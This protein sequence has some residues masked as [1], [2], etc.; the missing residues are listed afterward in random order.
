MSV[1]LSPARLRVIHG[2]GFRVVAVAFATALAFSTVPTPLYA[3]YQ[4][5]DGFP[6]F[7]VTVVFAA[8]AVGVMLSLYLA[9]HL[10]DWLGRR[11]VLVAGLLAEA[12]AAAMF[13]LW[14]DVPGLIIARL[15]SG[16]GI[17]VLSATATAHL[18]EL[19]AVVRPEAGLGSAGLVSTVV[20][21]GGLALGPLV[22]GLFAR[23]ATQ[24]LDTPFAVFLVVLPAE[25]IVVSLVPETVE[26]RE[27][28]PA[29]RPQRLSL[30]PA[31]R[32]AF[33]GA[34]AGAFA[35]FALS[36]LFMALAPTLLA[37]ELH[38]P[39]HLLAG[40]APFTMLGT[41]ALA[42]I[43][44]ARLATRPQL[45]SGYALMAGGLVVLTTAAF[46]GS[47]PLFFAASVLAGAGFGLG[48]RASVG[49]V[50]ALADDLTRGEVLAALFL[51]AYAGLVLPVLLV[52]LA[53]LVAPGAV[54]L[55]G[56]AALEL[57]LLGWS[58]RRTLGVA[59]PLRS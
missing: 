34:A 47:L 48:F 40:L 53:M 50:A 59:Q 32:T 42:Q 20:N 2:L 28:R 5:R 45:R 56:F 52:G 4:Q 18:S 55:A 46:A 17:G 16:A 25:A 22:G 15:L 30:P 14:P 29:Y 11:R 37:H 31:A 49:A 44:F 21:A 13:V 36:G 58:A 8:Y 54:V 38:Q 19:R 57:V 26:R 43:A 35:A 23:F 9:G 24:P 33:G 51:A 12:L 7:V 10:S 39:S 3:L 6:T 1:T 27:E 41:A